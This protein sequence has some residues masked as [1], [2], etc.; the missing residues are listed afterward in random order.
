MRDINDIIS[1]GGM[2]FKKGKDESAGERKIKFS[3]FLRG[4]HGSDSAKWKAG[5]K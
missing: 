3:D 4:T 2:V 5:F 1:G